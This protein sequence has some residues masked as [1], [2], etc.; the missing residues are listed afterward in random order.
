MIGAFWALKIYLSGFL[1]AKVIE[2]TRRMVG[3][4]VSRSI[5]AL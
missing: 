2:N 5:L 3:D 1:S 4:V